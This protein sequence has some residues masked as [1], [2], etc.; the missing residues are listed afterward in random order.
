MKTTPVT[1]VTGVFFYQIRA[2][3]ECI[4][5]KQCVSSLVYSLNV[6]PHDSA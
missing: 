5:I 4:V 1:I 6:S 3:W 2:F